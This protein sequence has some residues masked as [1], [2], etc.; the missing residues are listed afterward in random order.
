MGI[1]VQN[2]IIFSQTRTTKMWIRIHIHFSIAHPRIDP[3]RARASKNNGLRNVLYAYTYEYNAE[4]SEPL[5][6]CFDSFD[7]LPSSYYCSLRER[8]MSDN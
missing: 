4:T 7:N 3:L 8:E 2:H 5:R 1:N 6:K